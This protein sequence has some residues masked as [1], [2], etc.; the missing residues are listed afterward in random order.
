[1]SSIAACLG[2][3]TR[4]ALLIAWICLL[5]IHHRAPWLTMPGEFLLIAGLFY[6]IIDPGRVA[7]TLQP[8][9]DDRVERTGANLALRCCQVHLI[10]WLLFSVTSMLQYS[11][12]WNGSAVPLLS[13]QISSIFGPLADSSYFGQACTLALLGLQ[14]GAAFF[15]VH[16]R[17]VALG[18]ICLALFAGAVALLAGDWLYASVLIA[19]GMSFLPSH[20]FIST[21]DGN[22][23]P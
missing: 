22:D 6:C 7:W 3:G 16:P 2:V 13:R 4:L 8:G 19:M 12:W 23:I 15:L 1:M 9:W 18:L 17:I 11:V 5:M 14:F 10:I 21:T 20:S